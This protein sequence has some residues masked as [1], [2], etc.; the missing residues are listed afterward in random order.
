MQREDVTIK[1]AFEERYRALL[2]ERYE[3]FLKRSLTFL[4]RSVR[5][6]TLKAPRYTILRQLEAQ[7]TVEPVAWCPDGFFVEHAERRDIGNTTL[8]SLGLIYV[9]E[10][11]SMIPAMV[12]DPQ[13][14][15]RV[16]DMCASP[17]SKTT[18]IAQLMRNQGTLIANDIRGDRIKSLG[19]NLQ[20]C[21]VSNIIVTQGQGQFIK[22]EFDRILVDAPCSGTGAIRKSL[23][24]L[25]IW[26]PT[27]VSRLAKQQQALLARAY[28]MLRPGGTLVYSTCSVE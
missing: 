9:Q 17:G 3:E 5:I 25:L 19:L 24:T 7:F 2:G 20:R 21:G 28:A 4:R 11:A 22:G 13:P 18:H 12:L 27:M 26:N 6:N 1:P 16:L 8:H 14:G 10:A 23:K 15:E